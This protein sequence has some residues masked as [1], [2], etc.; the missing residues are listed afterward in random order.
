MNKQS[1]KQKAVEELLNDVLVSEDEQPY[2][3]P[4]NWVW[5]K[6]KA[7]N[8][9]K[10]LTIQPN[11]FPDEIFELYSVPSFDTKSPEYITGKEIASNKQLVNPNDIL[12]C[13][14]N[15]RINRVWCVENEVKQRQLAS[16][17]WIVIPDT[18][19]T[20]PK[21]LL[22]L[23]RSPFFRKLITSNVSGVGGSL[24]RARP[25]EVEKFPIPLPPIKEQKRIADKVER[26]LSKVDEAEQLIDQA[27][28]TFQLQQAAILDKAFRG[29]LTNKWRRENPKALNPLALSPEAKPIENYFPSSWILS[30]FQSIASDE[31][32]SLSIGPFGS[33]LK[34]AD[35]KDRGIPLIFVRNIR[36]S[37]YNLGTKFI[38]EEKAQELKAHTVTA[39]DVLVTKMG[40]PPGDADLC[41]NT[42]EK[43]I[44]TADCIKL[45]VN[46]EIVNNKFIM[47]A[48]R[49]SFVRQQIRAHSKGVAQQKITLKIFK[50]VE[51]PIPPYEEQIEI[52]N[53]L[54][55][56]LKAEKDILQNSMQALGK[57]ASLK[58]SILDTAFRGQLGINDPSEE[59][60]IELLKEML[61]KRA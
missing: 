18:K 10:R 57:I 44:I 49:S 47:Y 34:V 13:K 59:S 48:I 51:V 40:D 58:Q 46:K 52:V 15:P 60:A 36:S 16:T 26:L 14:I 19:V 53:F 29:E 54:D 33:N 2:S 22:Y 25:K 56:Y 21:Y 37:D 11:K 6:I 4:D 39:G 42:I 12:I 30:N 38:T 61:Q 5:I 32:Y 43:A 23:F 7:I 3:I 24:T 9:G 31:R 41:P 20:N 27:K 50:E 28:E 8:K 1:N 45:R 35:Y 55:N 17:E